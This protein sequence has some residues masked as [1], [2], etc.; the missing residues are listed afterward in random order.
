M[1]ARTWISSR[2]AGWVRRDDVG[3]HFG[4]V[5]RGTGL[6]ED[7]P[8]AGV[9]NGVFHHDP[10]PEILAKLPQRTGRNHR[11]GAITPRSHQ[12]RLV[13]TA[14]TSVARK[15]SILPIPR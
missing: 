12:N 4:K 3:Q 9:R 5:D 7:F 2:V 11:F 14:R 13:K 15:L 10:I 8:T 1:S 6:V